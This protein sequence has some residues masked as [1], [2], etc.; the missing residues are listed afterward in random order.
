MTVGVLS[1]MTV[2][3]SFP[4]KRESRIKRFWIPN[5]VG[6]DSGV[7]FGDDKKYSKSKKTFLLLH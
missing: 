2:V 6:D 7:V 1:G 5:Q 4:Q 3:M